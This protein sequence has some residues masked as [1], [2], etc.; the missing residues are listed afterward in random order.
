M[1]SDKTNLSAPVTLG[2][3]VTMTFAA[4]TQNLA[5]NDLFTV[6]SYAAG[7]YQGNDD[8]LTVK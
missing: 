5:V 4:G 8:S 1:G 2:E 6:N 3:G 7:Y